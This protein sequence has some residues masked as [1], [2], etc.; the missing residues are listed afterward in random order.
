MG[1]TFS[2]KDRIMELPY[3]KR[4]KKEVTVQEE[5]DCFCSVSDQNNMPNRGLVLGRPVPEAGLFDPQNQDFTL[6]LGWYNGETPLRYHKEQT[7]VTA[8][9]AISVCC[10]LWTVPAAHAAV[11]TGRRCQQ[12]SGCAC[13]PL[14]V[15][16]Y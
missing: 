8:S 5:M 3:I 13:Q 2:L 14:G 11:P 7:L 12:P 6:C 10:A 9:A 4:G 16:L 1:V 15:M